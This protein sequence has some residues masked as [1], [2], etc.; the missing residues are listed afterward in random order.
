MQ[1]MEGSS[2]PTS[3]DHWRK[4]EIQVD[5]ADFDRLMREWGITER[6]VE[7]VSQTARFQVLSNHAQ[8]MV[9]V[10]MAA[11]AALP[12]EAL[13]AEAQRIKAERERLQAHLTGASA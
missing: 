9:L 1:V 12:Q 2:F 5:D 11:L 4:L 7:L 10:R 6:A 3:T 13:A 8:G